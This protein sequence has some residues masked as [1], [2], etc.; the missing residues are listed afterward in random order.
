MNVYLKLTLK[1]IYLIV[2]IFGNLTGFIIFSK[3][4]MRKF[5]ILLYQTLAL[6]DLLYLNYV[7][8]VDYLYYMDVKLDT[9]S[10]FTCKSNNFLHRTFESTSPWLL[11]FISIDRYILI[12]FNKKFQQR[13]IIILICLMYV[14]NIVINVPAL[15]FFELHSNTTYF[16]G[17]IIKREKCS[18]SQ[19]NANILN[20]TQ[21]LNFIFLP[22]ILMLLFSIL[23][24]LAI[25]KSRL[26]ILKLGTRHDRNRLMKDVKFAISSISLNICY[27][28]LILPFG[29]SIWDKETE[30]Y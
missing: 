16:N 2:G 15:F 22:F 7:I 17:S 26:K 24:I 11:V 14:F 12:Q 28:A 10:S 3:K 1:T 5:P 9:M 20:I 30:F 18:M 19:Y 27:I 8:F 4:S 25:L 13:K 21:L 6:N 23:L 29:I